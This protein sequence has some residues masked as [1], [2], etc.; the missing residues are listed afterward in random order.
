LKLCRM[1]VGA[2]F[3][4]RTPLEAWRNR[5]LALRVRSIGEAALLEINSKGTDFIRRS[6]VRTAPPVAKNGRG[7]A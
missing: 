4:P 2:G 5:T 3:D 7:R 1:L 6:S